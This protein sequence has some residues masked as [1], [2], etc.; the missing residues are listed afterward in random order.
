MRGPESLLAAAPG[1][2]GRRRCRPAQAWPQFLGHD[3]DGR[4][5]AAVLG[6]PGPLLEPADDHAAA[7]LMTTPLHFI[8]DRLK[9]PESVSAQSVLAATRSDLLTIC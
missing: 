4:A 6:G 9:P 2:P 8:Q 1:D 7:P 5:G 3:L